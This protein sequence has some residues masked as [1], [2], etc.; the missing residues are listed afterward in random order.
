MLCKTCPSGKLI[1]VSTHCGTAQH[2]WLIIIM[3]ACVNVVKHA[4][5]K[6][7]KQSAATHTSVLRPGLS[8]SVCLSIWVI[9]PSETG[10]QVI[11]VSLLADVCHTFQT[12]FHCS[13]ASCW[14]SQTGPTSTLLHRKFAEWKVRLLQKCRIGAGVVVAVVPPCDA[15]TLISHHRRSANKLTDSLTDVQGWDDTRSG[16]D[17]LQIPLC[18]AD[19]DP[20]PVTLE[21]SAESA[22]WWRW[23]TFHLKLEMWANLFWG[24]FIYSTINMMHDTNKVE[25]L[26]RLCHTRGSSF[27]SV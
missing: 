27:L 13:H 5:Q 9:V 15:D 16:G 19:G 18:L 17:S 10:Q 25:S 20:P 26:S 4:V 8:Q 1:T 2:K 21:L 24:S 11:P 3:T 22:K 7:K 23:T 6:R 14:S 12:C